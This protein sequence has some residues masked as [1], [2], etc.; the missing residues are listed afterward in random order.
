M[1]RCMGWPL[2]MVALS[3]TVCAA[4]GRAPGAG[5]DE[6]AV[7]RQLETLENRWA[8]AVVHRDTAALSRLIAPRWVYTDESGVMEREA[9][10]KAFSSGTDTVRAAINR[11]MRA[12]VYPGTAV[13]IG[14]LEMRGRGPGGAFVHRYR[15]TDSWMLLEG[16]WQCIASQDYLIPATGRR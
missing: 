8:Q 9:G 10:I 11:D 6:R 14:I 5:A 13:V 1:R 7:A 4:Q 3:T 16:R 15:Y 2:A 12:L